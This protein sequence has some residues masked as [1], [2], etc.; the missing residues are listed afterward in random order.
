MSEEDKK[1]LG[2]QRGF[3]KDNLTRFQSYIKK[4]NASNIHELELRL[5]DI[6]SSL[7]EFNEEQ[8]R[9]A[10]QDRY[11]TIIT[12]AHALIE[13]YK[14][15]IRSTSSSSQSINIDSNV[16]EMSEMS[17]NNVKLPI[18]QLP[19]FYGNYEEWPSFCATF[20][21]LINNNKTLDDIEKF[22]YLLSSIKGDAEKVITSLAIT[23][24]NYPIAWDLLKKR[25]ENKSKL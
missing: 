3:I 4:V 10:F 23:K 8:E 22:H 17:R 24:E 21:T 6:K 18:I 14:P 19:K 2:Q 11:Y 7:K 13:K 5:V 1:T 12:Q 16:R 9:D 20:V 15:N 25:F